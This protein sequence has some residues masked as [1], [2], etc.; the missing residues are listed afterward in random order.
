MIWFLSW[1][2]FLITHFFFFWKFLWVFSAYLLHHITNTWLVKIKL[3]WSYLLKTFLYFTLSFEVLSFYFHVFI[4]VISCDIL[5]IFFVDLR[6]FYR[7]FKRKERLRQS[8]GICGFRFEKI[9]IQIALGKFV[10]KKRHIFSRSVI[11]LK[12]IICR[13]S[14]N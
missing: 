4:Q 2:W 1:F 5:C 12:I 13:I 3:D 7:N 14:N 8:F 6:W 10:L 11:K 9:I